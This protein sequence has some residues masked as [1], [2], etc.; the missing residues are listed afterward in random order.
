MSV[1]LSRIFCCL[2]SGGFGP[3]GCSCIL[4]RSMFMCTFRTCSV[5]AW[6]QVCHDLTH[7]A[8]PGLVAAA[9]L[10][11]GGTG[12]WVLAV[13]EGL[14]DK[15]AAVTTVCRHHFLFLSSLTSEG[16]KHFRYRGALMWLSA[17]VLHRMRSR[18]YPNSECV[19]IP[20][21]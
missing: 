11:E 5:E 18:P 15:L 16:G 12:G 6:I 10:L 13:E 9:G 14:D 7:A 20:L 4:Y 1:K 3:F 19:H 17:V 21:H 2:S 8:V